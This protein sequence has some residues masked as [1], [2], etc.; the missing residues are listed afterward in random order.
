M[1]RAV[2]PY[3][4]QQKAGRVITSGSPADK[5]VLPVNGA[6]SATKFA[7]EALSDAMRVELAHFGIQ[8]VLIEPGNMRSNF[9]VTAQA[10]ALE[11]FSNPDSPYHDL[12]QRY[13]QIMTSM[14]K[15]EPGPEIVF[16]EVQQAIEAS[17][18]KARYLVAVLLSQ[19]VVLR[20]G[21]EARECIFRRLFKVGLSPEH[22]SFRG[23]GD[24]VCKVALAN[25]AM[26]VRDQYVSTTSAQACVAAFASILETPHPVHARCDPR[27]RWTCVLSTIGRSTVTWRSYVNKSR[28]LHLD[29][30]MGA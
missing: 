10:N 13:L 26:W 23:S 8:V 15:S 11:I 7:L 19:R 12:Y 6:Y 17:K 3:L 30:P 20:L 4:Q 24:A 16:H 22:V 2:V 5:L 25:V 28:K 1:I 21:D 14:R 18:P 27:F 9:M 29:F